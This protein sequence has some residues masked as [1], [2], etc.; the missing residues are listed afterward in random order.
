MHPFH[1]S[2]NKVSKRV[3]KSPKTVKPGSEAHLPTLNPAFLSITPSPHSPG[4]QEDGK[5]RASAEQ[6]NGWRTP[7]YLQTMVP[8]EEVCKPNPPLALG[9]APKGTLTSPVFCTGEQRPKS[10]ELLSL[11]IVVIILGTAA[12]FLTKARY[13]VMTLAGGRYAGPSVSPRDGCL[14]C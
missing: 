1:R 2:G 12:T 14:H 5:Q 10:K 6:L 8:G 7:T 11:G 13:T 9:I 4:I 3:H